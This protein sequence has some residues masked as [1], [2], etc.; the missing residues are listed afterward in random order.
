MLRITASNCRFF[1]GASAAGLAAFL[2][3]A[4]SLQA[5]PLAP[6]PLAPACDQFAFNGRFEVDGSP[7]DMG[8]S[9][10]R[11]FFTS[12]GRS[13]GTP[14]AAVV[15]H[16]GGQ[17]KGNVTGG[18]IEGRSIN[19]QIKWNDKPD[20]VWRFWGTID[21]DG[22]AN[23]AEDGPGS[24]SAVVCRNSARLWHTCSRACQTTG[25]RAEDDGHRDQR[26]RHL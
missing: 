1:A 18:G 7:P 14:P 5:S 19:F 15:F 20:N 23:G 3:L 2:A 22:I 8:R 11:V 9:G 4:P 25:A 6:P 24:G 10:W 17:V 26:R 16:D 21:D 13:A 12:T